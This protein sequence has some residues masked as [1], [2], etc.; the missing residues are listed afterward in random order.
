MLLD[1]VMLARFMKGVYTDLTSFAGDLCG[2]VFLDVAFEKYITTI[3]GDRQYNE[4]KETSRK[5]MMKEFEFGI[6]RSFSEKNNQTYSVDLK[7]VE[8]DP[9]IGI[10]DNTIPVKMYEQVQEMSSV[11]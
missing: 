4:I 7:G 3:V 2:S 9:K 5:K 6:K 10:I 1:L 8:D 11:D